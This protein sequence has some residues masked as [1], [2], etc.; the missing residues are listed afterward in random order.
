MP[1]QLSFKLAGSQ[2]EWLILR[3]SASNPFSATGG[4]LPR[5]TIP[6]EARL[7]EQGID[8]EILRFAFDLKLGTTVIGQGEIGPV[9]YL[10]TSE[11][12]IPAMA[13]CPREALPY[14]LSPSPPQ[15]RLT[16][17][18]V[19][20]G[21]LRYQHSYEHG[22]GRAQGLAGPGVWHIESIGESG[23]HELD[24]QIARSDWYE[25]IVAP[26]GVGSYL[27]APLALPYG[28]KAWQATLTH[29]DEAGRAV[30][31]ANPPAIFGY[32]R[33]AI[34]AL[35]GAKTNIFDAMPE[36]PK[37]D[38]INELTKRIGEYIHSGRHVV[39]NSGGEQAGEFPVDQRDA[40]FV[41]NMTK[42]LLSQI[43]SLVHA[44]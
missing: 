30:V 31:Q 10:R 5:L 25:Q 12:Y 16:L 26:L 40:L 43:Y 8:I 42:L 36:G 19:L 18:L 28:V 14:L 41:Y 6:L 17:Q 23:I 38:A 15:G 11:H 29:L 7:T 13:T 35:P 33:A 44:P 34:D 37:R 20:K 9:T 1:T 3:M 39:P 2:R 4:P 21:L 24:V 27:I 22:D 32:C